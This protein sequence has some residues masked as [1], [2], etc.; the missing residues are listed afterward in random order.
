MKRLSTNAEP[1]DV[2]FTCKDH[3]CQFVNQLYGIVLWNNKSFV[4]T[5][6]RCPFIIRYDWYPSKGVFKQ[7]FNVEAKGKQPPSLT[8]WQ[9]DSQKGVFR[10]VTVGKRDPPPEVPDITA[11]HVAGNLPP[12]A[13]LLAGIF[14]HLRPIIRGILK[15]DVPNPNAIFMY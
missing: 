2:S 14:R 4:W 15:L 8:D 6:P 10:A 11:W 13:I 7:Y 9:L 1:E 12:P 5:H 3:H